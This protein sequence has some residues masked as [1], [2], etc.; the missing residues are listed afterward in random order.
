ME[1]NYYYNVR[2]CAFNHKR[3]HLWKPSVIEI[4][5]TEPIEDFMKSKPNLYEKDQG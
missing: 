2:Q 4:C 3:K 5:E 1:M